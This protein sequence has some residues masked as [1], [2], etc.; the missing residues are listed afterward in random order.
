MRRFLSSLSASNLETQLK[1]AS[2][3][4]AR[5]PKLL[6]I[7][8]TIILLNSNLSHSQFT[9]F[10]KHLLT[11]N[12][13]LSTLHYNLLLKSAS[14]LNDSDTF[15]NLLDDMK[16]LQI[17]LDGESYSQMILLN[18]NQSNFSTV[19]QLYNESRDLKYPLT[20]EAYIK[21]LKSMDSIM[22]TKSQVWNVFSTIKAVKVEPNLEF[23]F[24]IISYFNQLKD[25]KAA[26]K[27]YSILKRMEDTPGFEI[28]KWDDKLFAA[29]V[30]TAC[31]IGTDDSLINR[32]MFQQRKRGIMSISIV[33][34]LMRYWNINNK[35][36]ASLRIQ[37]YL[38]KI[39]NEDGLIPNSKTI[40]HLIDA[41]VMIKDSHLIRVV[42]ID[43]IIEMKDMNDP[44][45]F[46]LMDLAIR[47]LCEI[48]TT[49]CTRII[50]NLLLNL[51]NGDLSDEE[52]EQKKAAVYDI[53]RKTME[54][55]TEYLGKMKD[56]EEMKRLSIGTYER[57]FVTGWLKNGGSR[58]DE[59]FLTRL[60]L[61]LREGSC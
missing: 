15:M 57:E 23:M 17:P 51:N 18:Y 56:F 27:I 59:E 36:Y 1:N 10:Y 40:R 61:E 28:D 53:T 7:Q 9:P 47:A 16:T 41:C 49:T 39:G 4:L 19:I 38:K 30:D 11:S 13:T 6:G 29:C 46:H 14:N 52:C 2:R 44:E 60:V 20:I 43:R 55:V 45:L 32:I 22:I 33:N 8:D 26:H 12:I 25:P 5:Q 54:V 3:I 24:T 50:V 42:V 31:L 21:T 35:P 58:Q 48:P 37:K 34:S